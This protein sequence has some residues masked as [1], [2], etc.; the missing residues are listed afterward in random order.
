MERMINI[1]MIL[2]TC[3]MILASCRGINKDSSRG[4]DDKTVKELSIFDLNPII[5]ETMDE[6]PYTVRIT[7]S[8]Y[9]FKE[10]NLELEMESGREDINKIVSDIIA[11]KHYFEIESVED[12]ER[13]HEEIKKGINGLLHRGK[14]Q[15]VIFR[16][17]GLGEKK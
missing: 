5:A 11:K 17:F 3:M 1:K 15:K 4:I 7:I 2:F 6:K 16:D 13:L 8:L 9:Y 14:V 10:R 12:Y